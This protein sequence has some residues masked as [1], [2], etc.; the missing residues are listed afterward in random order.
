MAWLADLP[1]VSVTGTARP[2]EPVSSPVMAACP[3]ATPYLLLHYR[4]AV[5][6]L[7]HLSHHHAKFPFQRRY[8]GPVLPWCWAL[9]EHLVF[10]AGN[11]L[12]PASQKVKC[13]H[14]NSG[15][16][17]K[18]HQ[19]NLVFHPQEVVDRGSETQLQV[20]EI[21]QT[22]RECVPCVPSNV[23]NTKRNS[24][25]ESKK[26]QQIIFPFSDRMQSVRA[27]RGS[28]AVLIS[29]HEYIHAGTN[30]LIWKYHVIIL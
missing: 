20:G 16:Y 19:I 30:R 18:P 13:N 6:L 1:R 2:T 25:S 7:Q 14:C 5:V 23:L 15:L 27:L 28:D 21:V 24:I 26:H 9:K 29:E 11:P 4:C 10:T 12:L 3:R 22:R 17:S 8:A